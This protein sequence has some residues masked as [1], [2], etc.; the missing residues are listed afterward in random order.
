MAIFSYLCIVKRIQMTNEN[1][2]INNNTKTK[3]AYGKDYL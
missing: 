1:I 2:N 3:L